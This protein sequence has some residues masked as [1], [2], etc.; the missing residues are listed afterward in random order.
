MGL[1]DQEASIQAMRRELDRVASLRAATLV[2]ESSETV[3]NAI[4]ALKSSTG[5]ARQTWFQ[6]LGDWCQRIQVA[7]VECF[8]KLKMAVREGVQ[9]FEQYESQ[10][11]RHGSEHLMVAMKHITTAIETYYIALSATL[12]PLLKQIGQPVGPTPQDHPQAMLTTL[13][14]HGYRIDVGD[15]TEDALTH[16]E[17][18]FLDEQ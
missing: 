7:N 6:V 1:F 18:G 9:C 4:E 13:L 3:Q 5:T 14:G 15:I 11:M 17:V 2:H 8:T 10:T 12:E 16:S